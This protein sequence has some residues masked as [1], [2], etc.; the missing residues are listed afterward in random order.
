[1]KALPEEQI[2]TFIKTKRD[3]RHEINRVFKEFKREIIPELIEVRN[4]SISA[5]RN[6]YQLAG[7][8]GLSVGNDVTRT[9]STKLGLFWERIAD[10]APNVVSPELDFGIKIPEVDVIVLYNTNLYYTQLKTQK[11]TLTGS[12]CNRTVEELSKFP[13]SWFVAC[14]DTNASWTAPKS[15][16][17]LLAREFWDKIGIDYNKDIRENL[18]KLIKEIEDKVMNS[19]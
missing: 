3:R 18:D 14:I 19:K 13:H 15:L 9:F 1:M 8:T 17:R 16:N 10:L 12:Q 4:H 11:N 7:A 5:G 2:L 6:V